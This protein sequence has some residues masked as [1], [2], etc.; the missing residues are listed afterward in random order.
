MNIAASIKR[1]YRF[2]PAWLSA[3]ILVSATGCSTISFFPAESAQKAADKVIDDIWPAA[4]PTKK[5]N[6]VKDIKEIKDKAKPVSADAA[7]K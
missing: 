2:M 6:E 3:F 4:D 5:N 1:C 7:T